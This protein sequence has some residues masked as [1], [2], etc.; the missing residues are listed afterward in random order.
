MKYSWRVGRIVGIEIR[1][2]SSWFVI[3]ILFT[4]SLASS[5]FPERFPDWPPFQHWLIGL[6]TSLLIFA[7]V[8]IH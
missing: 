8:L 2:D 7:S 5:Y 3:L 4:W 6:M 1:I